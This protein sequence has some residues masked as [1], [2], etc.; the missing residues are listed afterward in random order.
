[1]N[2][3]DTVTSG[4]S[5]RVVFVNRYF[6]PDISA[7]SQLL[8]DLAVDLGAGP[9]EVHV[10]C[11][12]LLYDHPH[13]A[14]PRT[15]R[16]GPAWVHRCW[17][18]RFGRAGIPGRLLD[19]L[20]FY[21]AAMLAAWRLVRQDDILVALT[22][23]PMLS[24]GIALV[25]TRRRA[26][27]INWLQDLFPEVAIA[28]QVTRP[29]H[30]F[31]RL[32]L[33]LRNDSLRAAGANVVLGERMRERLRLQG[34]APE[35]IVVIENWADGEAIQPIEPGASK[36]RH[37]LPPGTEFVIEYSGNLGR[38]H[39]YQTI[40]G[41]AQ[42]LAAEPGW[43]FLMVGGGANM[44]RLQAEARQLSLPNMLF[45]P[46]RSRE[47]LADSLAA[48]DVH[49]SCLLPEMEGLIV[50]SK[51][52]GIL[53]AGR[54]LIVIGEADSEHARWVVAEACGRVVRTGDMGALATALRTSRA[55]REWV[56][57]AGG[58]SRRLYERRFSRAA[59][60][61]EWIRLIGNAAQ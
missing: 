46:Y 22:D 37:C 9:F 38:A 20:S 5:R 35:S 1:M 41:A 31:V 4:T 10:I 57:A 50:P 33:R 60:I 49:L 13:A 16:V 17:S 25:A 14:L 51:F 29:P 3:T 12:R 24:V 45:L 18:T 47:D 36:L 15:D 58:R 7:T 54:A 27:L 53:A 6:H 23:P 34:I 28:L 48:A 40:L 21:V 56:R 8:T 2:S 55:D 30:W 52:Y 59:A 44:I 61:Q 19:Y 26:V 32:L 43:L 42:I 39:D 11:S